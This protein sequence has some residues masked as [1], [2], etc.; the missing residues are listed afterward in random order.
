M[1][2]KQ[3]NLIYIFIFFLLAGCQVNEALVILKE[4]IPVDFTKKEYI[5]EDKV[6]KKND[7]K[8]EKK[9]ATKKEFENE[10]KVSKKTNTLN[11]KT[12]I[13]ESQTN[14]NLLA[15]VQPRIERE[16]IK[17]FQ[18]KK[19]LEKIGL[20]IPVSGERSFAGQYVINSLRLSLSESSLEFEFKVFDTK[21]TK[22]GLSEAFS[23]A[24]KNGIKVFIGP[25]FSDS[26]HY[27][28]S[29]KINKDIIIF[30][31]SSDQEALSDNI[32][33]TGTSLDEEFRCIFDNIDSQNLN[34]VAIIQTKN[35]FTEKYS[36]VFKKYAAE[37][38]IDFFS[39]ENNE[40]L[41]Q[42]IKKISKY[43]SRRFALKEKIKEIDN[44]E[45]DEEIKKSMKKEFER[46]ETFGPAPYEAIVVSA[47]GTKLV[48]I[49]SLL[50]YFDINTD[51]TFIIGT[52]GWDS[53]G[54]KKEN[55]FN[56]TFY[57]SN[58]NKKSKI[59]DEKYENIFSNAPNKI[60]YIT[61][62]L[63]IILENLVKSRSNPDLEKISF[64]GALGKTFFTRTFIT[65][66]ILFKKSYNGKSIVQNTCKS[67]INL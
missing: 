22:L 36:K 37:K 5:N 28:K 12:E 25:I 7:I 27:L 38:E 34:K 8:S 57:V 55:V 9:V 64:E 1:K 31:L 10:D 23:T 16:R 18:D 11:E 39:I 52:T 35:K 65:R 66:E 4:S 45:T 56:E 51:N 33:I 6:S 21:S 30:S 43:E 17:K 47:M 46:L 14:E 20:L 49:I 62:D 24:M 2:I 53:L 60:N 40:D 63:F 54:E 13:E 41:E 67:T 50:A 58:R 29:L 3:T 44:M 32:I 48:E 42:K 15:L 26:T 19:N 61:H 59:Y